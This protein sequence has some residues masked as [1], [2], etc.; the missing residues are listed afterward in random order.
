MSV[1]KDER[2]QAGV[3]EP[4]VP[5][6]Q[7][8]E[9]IDSFTEVDPSMSVED[10]APILDR[11]QGLIFVS[12]LDA[13]NVQG[14]LE[15]GVVIEGIPEL[16]QETFI[17]AMEVRLG[18]SVSLADLELLTRETVKFMRMQDRPVVDALVPEQNISSGTLQVLVLVGQLGKVSTENNKYFESNLLMRNIRTQP[19]DSI[20]GS[21]LMEDLR[22]INQNPFR[23]TD[24][25]YTQGDHFGETDI[26]LRTADR[27]PLRVYTGYEN[28]GTPL[29]GHNRWLAGI[30]W[31][32]AFGFDHLLN[33]QFTT[34]E[35]TKRLQAHSF[36]YFIPLDWRHKLWF[37]G[38][39]ST[40]E[41]D[42]PAPL[43]LKG[44]SW[45]VST[46]YMIP[47]RTGQR[48]EH[49]ITLGYDLM[50]NS[51]DLIFANRVVSN[52]PTT[53]SQFMSAYGVTIYDSYG[54]TKL[55]AAVRYSPGDFN[56]NNTDRAFRAS[57]A[58]ARANYLYARFEGER[59]TRLP[60]DFTWVM[61]ARGQLS[62]ANL[63]ASEQL[64]FGGVNSV[65]GY[66][67]NEVNADEGIITTQ[68]LHAPSFSPLHSFAQS[69]TEDNFTAFFFWDYGYTANR[70]L[71]PNEPRHI[72][73]SSIG[74]GIR[75]SYGAYLSAT[76]DWGFQLKDS[77]NSPNGKNSRAEFS[78]TA[79]Y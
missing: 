11:L 5:Q 51:N 42:L 22:W 50:D 63:V 12:S 69:K 17:Q 49:E 76:L 70:K 62:N 34:N 71:L 43:E 72:Q 26:I 16:N 55:N 8:G 1:L 2:G 74:P 46:R 64:S 57:R 38:S 13:V 35:V 47:F 48:F 21:R 27:Y 10:T 58:N 41:A 20:L 3:F 24:L 18:E 29:T 60:L 40:S 65:R 30:N 19:G 53:V 28:S 45:R 32:A 6:A 78:I 4:D 37:F 75:Y 59:G 39:Y 79:S 7:Q 61:K 23:Q 52:T 54:Y 67:T 68:E 77:G 31:G 14:R 25:V 44:K 66:E 73:L 36:S 56:N 9:V 15:T 33:Y